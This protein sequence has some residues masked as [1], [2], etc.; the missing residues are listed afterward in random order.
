VLAM[1]KTPAQ[2]DADELRAAM[3]GLGTD[4]DT[5]IEILTTRSNQQI[6]E[7]TRVYREELK[8]DL[9]K[10]ITSDTSGDFRNALLALAKGD[11]CEDM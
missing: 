1:L 8:R 3:K 7:I 10:D 9:A 5:L 11:R 4:E 6:R 2:F